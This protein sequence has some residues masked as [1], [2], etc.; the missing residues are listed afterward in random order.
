MGNSLF[1]LCHYTVCLKGLYF[2]ICCMSSMFGI[3]DNKVD[4]SWLDL[5]RGWKDLKTGLFSLVYSAAWL[6][7]HANITI[8]CLYEA[9]T[10]HRLRQD[11]RHNVIVLI[12]FKMMV[13][14]RTRSSCSE[15]K[16]KLL[17]VLQPKAGKCL[18]F[19]F[20]KPPLNPQAFCYHNFRCDL[21]I[22]LFALLLFSTMSGR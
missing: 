5:M 11:T 2:C 13:S 12:G 6:L 1:T 21:L 7:Q 10:K 14:A 20:A 17:G 16:K 8:I 9:Q 19:V 22:F 4:L 3:C 18:V 15:K